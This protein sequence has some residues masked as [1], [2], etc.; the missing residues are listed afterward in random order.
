MLRIQ[1]I[2][3]PSN[4]LHSQI[5]PLYVIA[6]A[7]LLGSYVNKIYSDVFNRSYTKETSLHYRNKDN[8]SIS[9]NGTVLCVIV[10]VDSIDLNC[11]HNPEIRTNIFFVYYTQSLLLK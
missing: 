1:C 5:L 4:K 8:T 7:Y 6:T 2:T 3:A 10:W 11:S 9:N